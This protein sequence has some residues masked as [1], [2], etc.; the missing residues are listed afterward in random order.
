MAFDKQP[1]IEKQDAKTA[2][3]I[4]VQAR[5]AFWDA[6]GDLEAQLDGIEVRNDDLDDDFTYDE[7][8]DHLVVL[9]RPGS[10]RESEADCTC[11]DRSWY[12][13]EHDAVCAYA[14]KPRKEEA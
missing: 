3:E 14:G 1:Y 8:L 7:F 5:D 4:A 12:G 9:N 10:E 2:F 6:L 11:G 13:S